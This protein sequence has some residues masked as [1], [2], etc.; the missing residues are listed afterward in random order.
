MSYVDNCGEIWIR[1]LE[2]KEICDLED[3]A[4][5]RYIIAKNNKIVV[6][7]WLTSNPCDKEHTFLCPNCQIWINHAAIALIQNNL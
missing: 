3:E 7:C 1:I 2:H 6:L 4:K 5:G